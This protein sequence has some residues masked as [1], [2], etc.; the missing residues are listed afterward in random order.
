MRGY[1]RT[2]ASVRESIGTTRLIESTQADR[3]LRSAESLFWIGFGFAAFICFR[4]RD[5]A[6]WG[7]AGLRPGKVASNRGI[8]EGAG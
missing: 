1:W 2:K 5:A 4:C 7:Q 6:R 3:G 8:P